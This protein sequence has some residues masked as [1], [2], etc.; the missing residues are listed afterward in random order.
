MS[1]AKPLAF[2][3]ATSG[4]GALRL[5]RG[6]YHQGLD[7]RAK[8]GTPVFALDDG[9]VLTSRD[10]GTNTGKWIAIKHS[11]GFISRYLHLDQ[12]LVSVGDWVTKGQQIA[13]SGATGIVQSA[14]HLHL[15]L[16]KDGAPVPSEPYVPADRYKSNVIL[17]AVLRGIPLISS[18][19][20]SI[21]SLAMLG[22]GTY[23]VWKY[24]TKRA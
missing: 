23:L 20:A 4:W 14:A 22:G 7:F 2:A 6:G 11:N 19:I 24:A 9:E 12:R 15:D 8:V 13:L 1:F 21:T 10:H 17:G 16:K 5:Y 18:P 3:Y